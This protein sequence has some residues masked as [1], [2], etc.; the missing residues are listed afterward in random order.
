[1]RTFSKSSLFILVTV[2]SLII[3]ACGAA[4]ASSTGG[5]GGGTKHVAILNKDMTDAEIKAEIE[6][7]GSLI[8][9]NWTYTANDELVKQ[10]TQYV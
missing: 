7:E 6:K 4:P 10:F 8:V 2:L 9:G 1:M 3:N 5:G